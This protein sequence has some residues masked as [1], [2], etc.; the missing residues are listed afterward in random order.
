[1]TKTLEEL[2]RDLVM[3]VGRLVEGVSD[4]GGAPGTMVD[5]DLS[6]VFTE[7]GSLI[8]G[9]LYIRTAVAGTGTAAPPFPPENESRWIVGH[10]AT[11]GTLAVAPA[12]TSTVG[13]GDSYEIYLSPMFLPQWDKAINEAISEVWPQ[14]YERDTWDTPAA[15]L[16]SYMLP[17]FIEAVEAVEVR[18]VGDYR[19]H[20]GQVVPP[21]LWHVE[22]TP[23]DDL[24]L[25]FL[26]VIPP[27]GREL[28]IR[29]KA[30][31]PELAAYESTGL[32]YPYIMAAGK[33]NAYEMLAAEHGG[34]ADEGRYL[35]LMAHWAEEAKERKNHLESFLLDVPVLA[36]AKQ[37]KG[38]R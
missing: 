22:G 16:D 38:K 21:R 4:S 12:F 24:V 20:G 5:A 23:G 17:D 35:Q 7:P 28:R 15:D 1:M 3:D 14:V 32:D 34:Q 6:G 13:S 33:R 31:Y 18:M 10:S 19:G 8:G 11:G 26:R 25:R 9:L 29:Y 2:R 30:R 36:Q 27:A 37:G